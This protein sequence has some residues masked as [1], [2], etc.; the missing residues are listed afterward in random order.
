MTI[1]CTVT[2]LF[3]EVKLGV[4]GIPKYGSESEFQ[5]PNRTVPNYFSNSEKS[6]FRNSEFFQI[7]EFLTLYRIC[8]QDE[9]SLVSA[10]F[11][12]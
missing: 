7:S 4:C 10:T 8:F 9:M 3:A 11:G 5:K 12:L 1:F 6:E 2:S